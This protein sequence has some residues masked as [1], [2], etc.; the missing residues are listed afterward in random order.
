VLHTTQRYIYCMPKRQC[1]ESEYAYRWHHMQH[2]IVKKEDANQIIS[3][4]SDKFLTTQIT[5]CARACDRNH[6]GRSHTRLRDRLDLL[7]PLCGPR[8]Y[9]LY[10]YIINVRFRW[11]NGK[12]I[13]NFKYYVYTYANLIVF[14]NYLA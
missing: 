3:N 8:K 11:P 9:C 14:K 1:A 2:G 4:T 7:P 6:L 5:N 12:T 10:K 13:K